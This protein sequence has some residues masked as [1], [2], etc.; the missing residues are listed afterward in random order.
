MMKSVYVRGDSPNFEIYRILSL[1]PAAGVL[2]WSWDDRFEVEARS[3]RAQAGQSRARRPH[4]VGRLGVR[5]ALARA[6]L[7][8]R[9]CQR[10]A[11][12]EQERSL[13]LHV[14]GLPQ[15]GGKQPR[16]REIRRGHFQQ[17][18]DPVRGD[19]PGMRWM[20]S[21]RGSTRK[22]LTTGSRATSLLSRKRTTTTSRASCSGPS[23]ASSCSALC[24]P[25]DTARSLE[26][27]TELRNEASRAGE[28]V[29]EGESRMP[30][31]DEIKLTNIG[32]F[33]AFE[34]KLHARKTGEA[35]KGGPSWNILLGNNGCGKSTVLRAVAL[36]LC[37]DDREARE[38]GAR[39]LKT[40]TA[41]GAIEL[42]FGDRM[43]KT[44]LKSDPSGGSVLVQ[45][46]LTPL[47]VGRWV[48]LGF[49]ALRGA[50]SKNPSGPG[51]DGRPEPLVRDVLP[52]LVSNVD[53]RFDSI[54]QWIVNTDTKARRDDAPAAEKQKARKMLDTFFRV[55]R[56]FVP[57]LGV[58][59]EFSHVDKSFTIHVKTSDG[60]VPI[61][62]LSQGTGSVL[63][64]VGTLLQRMYEIYPNSSAPENEP[65]LVLI[66][67]IDA[68]MHPEW[69]HALVGAVRKVFPNVQ[70]V[71]TTHS[72]LIVG[73]LSAGE[74]TVLRR[75]EE[76]GKIRCCRRRLGRLPRPAFRPDPDEHPL[77]PGNAPEPDSRG[78][79]EALPGT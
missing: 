73:D 36:G 37:G 65:A 77:R 53:W 52:L 71:A 26:F 10:H 62:Q 16:L 20:N 48:A 68:H 42:K 25:T 23:T 41:S 51:A 67:E 22:R 24:R 40:G 1:I 34:I 47:Q 4:V 5:G 44:T 6:D 21:S 50:S 32:P 54:K 8:S 59:L 74:V 31:L 17:P 79:D 29:E 28:K 9:Q 13:R 7:L 78:E 19:R 18:Y 15:E 27:L 11:R 66:D 57:G 70:V 3:S 43:Y 55:Q 56:A 2:N 49:A 46:G 14:R 76:T 58:P 72:A 69:Q 75:D 39:L 60:V 35:A 12:R 45:S 61:D 30:R 63:G 38:A 33:D 64:W